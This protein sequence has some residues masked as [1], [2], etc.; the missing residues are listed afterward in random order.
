[1]PTTLRLATLQD[2]PRM[3]EIRLA[4]RENQLSNPGRITRADYEDFVTGRGRSWVLEQDGQIVGF[5]A[6]DGENATIW[7][8]FVDP[9]HEGRGH[10]RK[11]LAAAVDWLWSRGATSIGLDTAPQ[12]R[13]DRL[14][15][16]GGWLVVGTSPH[17]E[18]KFTLARPAAP[19]ADT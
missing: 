3:S 1:M 2:I 7:A 11:L 18:L 9:A 12:T 15:R 5:S 13:A 16:A 17:G 4:V 6:A 8:L 14:Y 10:G 19:A